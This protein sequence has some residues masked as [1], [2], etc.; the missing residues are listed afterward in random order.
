LT[1]LLSLAGYPPGQDSFAA[2][3]SRL[4]ASAGSAMVARDSRPAGTYVLNLLPFLSIPK[5]ITHLPSPPQLGAP[6]GRRAGRGTRRQRPDL[7]SASA[8][9]FGFSVARLGAQWDHVP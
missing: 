4:Q 5:S 2:D 6:A 3:L 9:S 1:R 7:T 8:P